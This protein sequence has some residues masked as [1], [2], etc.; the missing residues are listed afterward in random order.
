MTVVF[1][2]VDMIE[3]AVVVLAG[4]THHTISLG[5]NRRDQFLFGYP[6][7]KDKN[8][9]DRMMKMIGSQTSRTTPFLL[10]SSSTC[11]RLNPEPSFEAARFPGRERLQPV[12]SARV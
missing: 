7:L 8:D 5:M 6:A 3:Q 12:C 11:V 2:E 4:V 1:K 9:V 10:R